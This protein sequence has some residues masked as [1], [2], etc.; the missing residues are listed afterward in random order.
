VSQENAEIVVSRYG[1]DP[2]RIEIVSNAVDTELFRPHDRTA[3][4]HK[5]GLP[6]DAVILS[7]AGHFIERK[8]VYRVVEAMNRVEGLYGIFLGE[9]VQRPEGPRVLHAGQAAHADVP[10][11]LSASDFFV[12]PTLAEGSP[13]AI[14]EAMACGLPIVSSDIASV[15][16]TVDE[17][18][19]IL[20]DPMDVGA[21]AAV[22]EQLMRDVSL[23]RR[24]G[25]GALERGRRT[26]LA[27]RARRIRDWLESI[28][29]SK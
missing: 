3:M 20:V 8:G 29:G 4:R 13:N 18:S 11:W 23:R 26:N 28:V 19:A 15:R 7:F 27:I 10:E 9:G 5:H 16:E 25:E 14:I 6:E 17:S 2:S 1:V 21:I 22:L 24:L 12:L